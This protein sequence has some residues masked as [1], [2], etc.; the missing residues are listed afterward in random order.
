MELFEK[1]FAKM[2][3]T[4]HRH[5]DIYEDLG[6]FLLLLGQADSRLQNAGSTCYPNNFFQ[7]L[8]EQSLNEIVRS[9]KRTRRH[10]GHL[11][12]ATRAASCQYEENLTRFPLTSPQRRGWS[13]RHVSLAMGG[14]EDER[15]NC[16][17]QSFTA[18]SFQ[19]AL[20]CC[21]YGVWWFQVFTSWLMH[22]FQTTNHMEIW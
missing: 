9:W 13:R 4:T 11:V 18:E 15:M 20:L 7:A 1:Q 2:A 5:A 19:W 21:G 16:T 6:R 17:T 10:L 14:Y 22:T 3:V 12:G 8:Q